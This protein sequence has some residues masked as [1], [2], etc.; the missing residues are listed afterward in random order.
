MEAELHRKENHNTLVSDGT[1][2]DVTI[3][4]IAYEGDEE[5]LLLT[6]NRNFKGRMGRNNAR[7]LHLIR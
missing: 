5:K 6:W 3:V 4:D 7:D 2:Y 1:V